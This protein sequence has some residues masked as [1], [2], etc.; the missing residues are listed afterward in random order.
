M[1][2]YVSSEDK[3]KQRIQRPINRHEEIILKFFGP[4]NSPPTC[5]KR[6]SIMTAIA[7]NANVQNMVTE[8]PKLPGTTLNSVPFVQW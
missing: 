5:G 7:N 1:T 8:K 4:P 6:L 2:Q 3:S